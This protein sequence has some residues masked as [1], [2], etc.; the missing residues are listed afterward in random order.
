MGVGL[1]EAEVV[2][3]WAAAADGLGGEFGGLG[4]GEG[5]VVVEGY[6][7]CVAACPAV[8]QDQP[9]DNPQ[10]VMRQQRPSAISKHNLRSASQI[11]IIFIFPRVTPTSSLR[12]KIRI[13]RAADI[14]RTID[15]RP[16]TTRR[17]LTQSR[18]RILDK[19]CHTGCADIAGPRA[20]GLVDAVDRAEFVGL[21]CG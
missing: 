3:F 12:R 20:A 16:A 7:Y 15:L 5:L 10:L 17:K 14:S 2:F 6:F 19:G 18:H 13:D 9:A 21:L 1:V 8:D 11:P 4:H